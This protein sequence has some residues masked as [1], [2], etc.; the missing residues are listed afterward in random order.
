VYRDMTFYTLDVPGNF[1]KNIWDYLVPSKIV[2]TYNL[3]Y[4]LIKL[5]G[6]TPDRA[7]LDIYNK[8]SIFN[9]NIYAE[10]YYQY[11]KQGYEDKVNVTGTMG[12]ELL[13]AIHRV[14]GECTAEKLATKLGVSAYPHI[15][16]FIRNYLESVQ[17]YADKTGIHI[18]DLFDWEVF[19]PGWAGMSATE[20]DIAREELR[21]VNHRDLISTYM[22][23][24]EKHRFWHHPIAQRMVIKHNWPE[25]LKFSVEPSNI[26]YRN[27]KKILRF[28]HI[29][30]FVERSHSLL[31][32]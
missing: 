3:K 27:L 12:N 22:L 29:E 13:R 18:I 7:F 1:E 14:R 30:R 19:C 8:N 26:R 15:L 31:N 20:H 2:E 17:K 9:R 32:P 28:L 11:I 4:N 6:E 25:L 23:I 24:P 10:V 5:T 21:I 16:K